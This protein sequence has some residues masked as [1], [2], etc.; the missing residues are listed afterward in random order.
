MEIKLL[1]NEEIN[2]YVQHEAGNTEYF[3]LTEEQFAEIGEKIRSSDLNLSRYQA[4]KKVYLEISDVS[5]KKKMPVLAIAAAISLL[6]AFTV[7]FYINQG[8]Y[9]GDAVA[10]HDGTLPTARELSARFGQNETLENR[11]NHP[12]RSSAKVE[13]LPENS[14]VFKGKVDF[15]WEAKESASYVLKVYDRD[16]Q[17]LFKQEVSNGEVDWD[18]PADGV[19]YWSLEDDYEVFHWGKVFGLA[20]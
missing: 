6:I 15:S 18:V 10:I 7:S 12:M 5:K 9:D 20:H 14:G 3:N 16:E 13:I 2:A 11:V 4:S 19:Y 17:L 8:G 1:T